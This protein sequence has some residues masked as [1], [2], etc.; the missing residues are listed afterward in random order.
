MTARGNVDHLP[1]DELVEWLEEVAESARAD[2]PGEPTAL[3]YGP[4]DEQVIDLYGDP[5]CTTLVISVHG[6]YFAAMY[7]RSVNEPVARALAARPGT[8]V[9]NIDYRR[10]GSVSTP[11]ETVDD[12]IAAVAAARAATSAS[13]VVVVG[14]SAGGYLALRLAEVPGVDLVI[15]LSPAIDLVGIHEG[16]FDEGAVSDWI[17][18]T[19]EA[20][21]DRWAQLII[22]PARWQA[23]E[24]WLVHGDE[25]SVVP[26]AH[27]R[28]F[29]GAH[30]GV[31]LI[32]EFLGVGHFEFL[33]PHSRPSGWVADL[34]TTA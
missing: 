15:A 28:A 13:R 6:G 16:R 14:H 10:A 33:D 12:V 18:C 30:P 9:A 31:A 29:V 5:Q 19:P 7:D 3:S 11:T 4:A 32:E 8:C 1:D 2:Y 27:T 22:D 17:G 20:D 34:A 24:V 21:P 23:E 26:V 25:D